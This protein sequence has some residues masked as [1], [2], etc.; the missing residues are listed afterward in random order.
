MKTHIFL[1]L[2][3]FVSITI[4]LNAQSHLCNDP[5]P[6]PGPLRYTT[7]VL[8]KFSNTL[9]FSNGQPPETITDAPFV[10]VMIA[11]RL[12][13]CNGVTSIIIEDYVFVDNRDW[14]N[15]IAYAGMGVI[16]APVIPIAQQNACPYPP[17]SIKQAITDA[18]NEL[19]AQLGNPAQGNFEIYFKGACN[20]TVHLSFPDG[21][22]IQS[23]PDDSGRVETTILSA[24]SIVTQIIPC[25][26]IC[27]KVTYEWRKISVE[28]GVT[29]SRWTPISYEGDDAACNV[30]PMPDFNSYASKLQAL[31][32]NPTTGQHDTIFGSVVSQEQC[33]LT[34]PRFLSPPPEGIQTSVKT[35]VSDKVEIIELTASPIPFDNYIQISTSKP[36]VRVVVFDMKGRKVMTTQTSENGIINTS[37]LKGGVYYIQ[38]HFE[39]DVVKTIKVVKH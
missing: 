11:Y 25:G 4:K 7:I 31:I 30:S 8:C 9:I 21:S 38:V 37:D 19:L 34:C 26:D 27:C 32:Y 33:E 35:D 3:I 20:S 17:L 12:R 28:N 15:N 18:I 6:Q 16:N 14:W 36:L 22:F 29:I 10:Q 1:I 2:T 23:P 24:A 5:C 13:D 39:S